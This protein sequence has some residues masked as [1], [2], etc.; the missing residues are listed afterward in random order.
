MKRKLS[1]QEILMFCY[2]TSF[3]GMT[4]AVAFW[5]ARHMI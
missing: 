4:A 5:I 1:E 3:M 2:A